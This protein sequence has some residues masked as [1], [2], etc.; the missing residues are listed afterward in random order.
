MISLEARAKHGQ[1]VVI[2]REWDGIDRP[3]Y[4]Q[5]D[6]MHPESARHLA[7]QLWEA[8]EAIDGKHKKASNVKKVRA[9]IKKTIDEAREAEDVWT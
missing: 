1:V 8:A 9:A 2:A 5:I 4:R 3:D 6:A 7:N